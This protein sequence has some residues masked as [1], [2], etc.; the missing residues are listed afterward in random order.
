VNRIRS[1]NEEQRRVIRSHREQRKMTM[2]HVRRLS[3]KPEPAANVSIGTKI[4]LVVGIL[5]AVGT[6]LA[7][8]YGTSA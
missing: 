6:V 4:E 2:K 8:K 1:G 3:R 7:A 5:A